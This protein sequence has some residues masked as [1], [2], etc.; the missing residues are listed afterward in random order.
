MKLIKIEFLTEK[1]KK[2]Y[3][4]ISKV[5]Q[6]IK[7]R[8]IVNTAFK[9]RKIDESRVEIDIKISWLAIKIR[10]EENIIETMS[11]KDCKRNIDYTMEVT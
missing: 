7:E 2:A 8:M 5:K 11:F 9:E 3:N 4:E 6:S 1:G 10:L